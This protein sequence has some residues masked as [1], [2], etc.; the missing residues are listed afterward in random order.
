MLNSSLLRKSSRW[1]TCHLQCWMR[2]KGTLYITIIPVAT[3]TVLQI[4]VNSLSQT[5]LPGRFLCPAKWVQLFVADEVTP[6]P[7]HTWFLCWLLL[8]SKATQKPWYSD[9]WQ[10]QK[11]QQQRNM[12]SSLNTKMTCFSL[13]VIESTV[14]NMV[15]I[16]LWQVKYLGNILCYREHSTLYLCPDVVRFTNLQ[17]TKT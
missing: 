12:C 15:D 14:F 5:I 11:Y 16:C 7:H 9:N 4:P 10:H 3:R 8:L 2:I 6:A 17:S 13:P 1:S